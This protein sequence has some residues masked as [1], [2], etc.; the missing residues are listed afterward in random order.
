MTP[1]EPNAICTW[2]LRLLNGALIY[3][4]TAI[5]CT[6]YDVGAAH[7]WFSREA[8]ERVATGPMWAL[9]GP[10]AVRARP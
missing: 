10:T 7:L 4:P 8:A 2:M 1:S 5:S 6:G 3:D 9:F